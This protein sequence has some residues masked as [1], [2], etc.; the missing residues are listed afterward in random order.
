MLRIMRWYASRSREITVAGAWNPGGQVV[1]G[2]SDK[3]PFKAMKEF[4][5]FRLDAANECLWR[6]AE[7]IALTPKAFSM[8]QYIVDR[9]GQLVTQKDLLDGLWDETFVQPE[10][11]KSHIMDIRAALGDDAKS[12]LFIETQ[13]RRGYRFIAD[14]RESPEPAIVP[15]NGAPA[16]EGVP[17]RV[18]PHAPPMRR[19]WLVW[20]AAGILLAA[21]SAGLALRWRDRA[22]IAT[23]PIVQF[24]IFAPEHVLAP[25]GARF[26]VSPDGK[27]L[28]FWG[29]GQDGIAQLWLRNLDSLETRV[30]PGSQTND[31]R[32]PPIWSPDSRFVA[33]NSDGKLEEDRRFGRSG[34]SAVRRTGRRYRGND[35]DSR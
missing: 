14:V 12:P 8:L 24:E 5:P 31:T 32:L 13:P 30:L 6:G 23:A 25:V 26:A 9:A 18:K 15:A 21:S 16:V 19:R 10:V 35:V 33:F 28:V 11:L 7:R 2:S 4:P 17:E 1:P 27:R 34:A 22:P 3:L 20:I 29:R